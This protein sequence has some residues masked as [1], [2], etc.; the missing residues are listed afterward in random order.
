MKRALK[1]PEIGQVSSSKGRAAVL[2][3]VRNLTGALYTFAEWMKGGMLKQY[4]FSE[5]NRN[6]YV[7]AVWF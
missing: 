1:G 5:V 3:S 6:F 2:F 7:K 4:G